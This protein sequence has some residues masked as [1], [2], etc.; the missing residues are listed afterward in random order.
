MFVHDNRQV[1]RVFSAALFF[2]LASPPV[3]A[4]PPES[5]QPVVINTAQVTATGTVTEL[6]IKNQATGVTLRYFG[7]KLDQGTSYALTGTG[8]DLLSNG[9]RISASGTLAGNVFNVTLF[10]VLAQAPAARMTALA[11]TSK[12]LTGTLAVYHKDFFDQGRGEY[13]LAVRDASDA[14]TQLNVAAIPDSLEIGMLVN[15]DGRVA[16]DGSSLDVSNITIIA[17]APTKL[18]EVAAVPV[19]NNVLVLPI[20][21]TDSSAT[22]PFTIAAISN[23]FQTKVMPYYQEVSYGQQLLS[24]TVANNSGNWLNA[25]TTTPAGCDYTDHRFP[26]RRCRHRNG[27]QRQQLPEPLLRHAV[28]RVRLGGPRVRWLGTSLEQRR[29]RSVGLWPRARPQFRALARGIGQLRCSGARRELRRLRIWRSVRRHGQHSPDAFQRDAEGSLE[30]DPVDVG[31]DPRVGNA[32]V[33]AFARWNP[34]VSRPTPIKI[35]TSNVKRTYWVEFR[36]PIGFDSSAFFLAQPRRADSRG[37]AAIR[38][39]ERQRRHGNSGHDAGLRRW[40]RRRDAASESPPYV[41]STTGVTISV[42]SATPGASGVLTVQVAMGGKTPT[43][44]TLSSSANPSV[45]GTSV[46]FTATVTG[47]APT[48]TVAFTDGGCGDCRLQRGG[49]ARGQPQM[50]RWRRAAQQPERGDAHH[51]RHL[52]RGC[53]EQWLDQRAVGA[54]GQH[55]Q[56]AKQ[57]DAVE[58]GEPV[59][60]RRECDVHGDGDWR[61]RRRAPSRSPM[62]ALRSPAA[63]PWRCPPARPMRRSR[64]ARPAA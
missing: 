43:T 25:G 54:G 20:K 6:T 48:G 19:T 3:L 4:H 8:L 24:V 30:L 47:A 36:Q 56:G 18:S 40:L 5:T 63:A 34:A 29:E 15:A 10:S 38:L 53:S 45:V 59:A 16:A 39:R 17:P 44:T 35:P 9:T 57:H 60:G 22:D 27:L 12:T 55:K 50:P 32:D 7:L 14:A 11:Q 1:L 46:T 42:L 61:R 37:R 26:C 58:F 41:D 21:F 51:R 64:P 2:A 28:D 31:Q 33:S 52:R 13:G 49:A 23:E 62:A